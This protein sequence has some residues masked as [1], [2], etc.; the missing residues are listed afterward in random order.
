MSCLLSARP[1]RAV[2]ATFKSS[3]RFVL[4]YRHGVFP[5]YTLSSKCVH[6]VPVF[7]T[8]TATSNHFAA[9]TELQ[10]CHRAMS[11]DLE[12]RYEEES[13]SRKWLY[14]YMLAQ[15]EEATI[16]S[17]CFTRKDRLKYISRSEDKFYDGID[18]MMAELPNQRCTAS[19]SS[20]PLSLFL[21]LLAPLFF[22]FLLLPLPSTSVLYL[23]VI[24]PH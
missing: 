14:V 7:C 10:H 5:F 3:V 24:Q 13:T 23:S 21:F 15:A 22:L 8:T 2:H 1:L 6:T 20:P 4:L 19:L 16:I 17:I 18:M 12:V 11:N 9:T